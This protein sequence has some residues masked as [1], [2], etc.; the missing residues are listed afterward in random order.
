M[1]IGLM[2]AKRLLKEAMKNCDPISVNSMNPGIARLKLARVCQVCVFFC[3][4]DVF[5]IPQ[6]SVAGPDLQSHLFGDTS[7]QAREI[8]CWY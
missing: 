4:L 2:E 8:C 7:Q 3:C 6:H 5:K 1:C